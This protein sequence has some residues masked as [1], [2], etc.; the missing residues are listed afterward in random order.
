MN[1]LC[2]IG[3]NLCIFF[4]VHPVSVLFIIIF[5]RRYYS[6]V[7]WRPGLRIRVHNLIIVIFVIFFM[8]QGYLLLKQCQFGDTTGTFHKFLR[9]MVQYDPPPQY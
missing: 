6:F 4:I 2:V 8:K 1:D 5:M 9:R 3:C 7:G